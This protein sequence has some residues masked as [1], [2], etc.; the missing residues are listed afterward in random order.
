MTLYKALLWG[1]WV[2]DAVRGE[3]VEETKLLL[4]KGGKIYENGKARP[5]LATP[6]EA[7]ICSSCR[8]KI[9]HRAAKSRLLE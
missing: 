5:H 2:Q 9:D 8:G 1:D 6:A 7:Q 3:Y 4:D